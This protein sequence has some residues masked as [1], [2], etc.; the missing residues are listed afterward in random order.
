MVVI[1]LNSAKNHVILVL[2][3]YTEN[4]SKL[5]LSFCQKPNFEALLV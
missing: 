5:G 1:K 4:I 2:V 3:H